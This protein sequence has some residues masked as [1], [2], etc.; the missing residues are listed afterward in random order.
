MYT[1]S[2]FRSKWETLLLKSEVPTGLPL[3]RW[4]SNTGRRS[5]VP[6]QFIYPI[7]RHPNLHFLTEHLVKR[8]IIQCVTTAK[9]MASHWHSFLTTH[10][11]GRAVGVECIPGPQLH[12]NTTSEPL[13]VYAS[14]WVIVSGGSLGSPLILERSGI[15][16]TAILRK[17][18]VEQVVDLPGVGE[19]YQGTSGCFSFSCC[20]CPLTSAPDHQIAASVF[21]TSDDYDTMDAFM[22]GDPDE[23]QS[24]CPSYTCLRIGQSFLDKEWHEQWL[25]DGAGMMANKLAHFYHSKTCKPDSLWPCLAGSTS[26][27][28]FVRSLKPKSRA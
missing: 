24:K 9:F 23:R 4:I 18:G 20:I 5:D 6:H 16:S 1:S 26:R 2:A 7:G 12:A 14:K 27:P 19:R 22:R 3:L 8:V 11:D 28:R 13:K 17:Y 25:K 10:R 21:R 15:G